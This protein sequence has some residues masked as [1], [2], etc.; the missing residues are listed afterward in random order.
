MTARI[1]DNHSDVDAVNAD[2]NRLLWL[3]RIFLGLDE[4]AQ[5]KHGG[6]ERCRLQK[7]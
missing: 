1:R 4:R 7:T 6:K 3:L 5:A 2:V